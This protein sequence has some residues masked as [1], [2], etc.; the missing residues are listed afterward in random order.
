[1]V[2]VCLRPQCFIKEKMSGNFA[3]YVYDGLISYAS[4]DDLSIYHGL[5][6]AAVFVHY[7]HDESSLDL[8]QAFSTAF[9]TFP[10]NAL[11]SREAM[12]AIVVP[13]GDVIISRMTVGWM[14]SSS[15]I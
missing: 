3:H 2:L 6:L 8:L 12:P 10:L 7:G 15:S 13:P 14:F 9:I 1:M 11:S 5:S 4:G